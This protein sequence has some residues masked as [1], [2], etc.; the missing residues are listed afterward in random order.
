MVQKYKKFISKIPKT[1]KAKLY[2]LETDISNNHLE[3]YDVVRIG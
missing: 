2:Q 3:G 1:F